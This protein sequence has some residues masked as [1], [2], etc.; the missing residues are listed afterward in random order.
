MKKILPK[1][2][3]E[4]MLAAFAV[5]NVDAIL[6]RFRLFGKTFHLKKREYVVG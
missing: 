3:V 1:Q 2:V 4:K 5:E 6:K